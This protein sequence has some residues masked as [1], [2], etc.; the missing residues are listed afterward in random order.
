MSAIEE[1]VLESLKSLTPEQQQEVL[2]FVNK[3]RAR[4]AE[5]S[6]GLHIW[7]VIAGISGQLPEE[8][9]RKLPADGAVQHDHYLYGAPKR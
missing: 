3:L 7:D 8:D 4:R 1:D 6:S 5:S 2:E 9:W